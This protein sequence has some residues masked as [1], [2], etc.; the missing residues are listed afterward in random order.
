MR[1][2]DALGNGRISEIDI[3][4]SANLLIGKH[5][6]DAEMAAAMK[7]DNM[8][9]AGDIDSQRVWLRIMNAIQQLQD[10]IKPERLN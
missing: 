9:A 6:D 3:Y 8:L 4:R 1:V 5:G 2:R 7:A 10:T